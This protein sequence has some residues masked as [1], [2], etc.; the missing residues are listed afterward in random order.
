MNDPENGNWI[1]FE[2]DRGRSA[3][4][5]RKLR[6]NFQDH[7]SKSMPVWLISGAAFLNGFAGIL[8]VLIQRFSGQP[9][10]IDFVLPL[11]VYHWNSLLTLF[12]GFLLI[13][14]SFKL[15]QRRRSAWWLTLIG[16]GLVI[17]TNIGR[18]G[19]WYYLLP[20]IITIVLLIWGYRR[21]SVRSEVMNLRREVKLGFL[22][23]AISLSY[24]IAGFWLLDKK[25]F[26]IEFNL[27]DSI[28]RTLRQF[29]LIGNID[30]VARTRHATWFMDSL[31]LMGIIGGSLFFYSLFRPIEYHLRILPSQRALMKTL[32]VKFGVSSED[33]FK[34]WPEKSYF[35][36]KNGNA[37]IAYR[38]SGG[39]AICLGDPVGL[40]E[41]L[42]EVVEQFMAYCLDN[43]WNV[44]FH[45]ARPDMLGIY[46]RLGLQSIKIGEEALINLDHF[47]NQSFPHNRHLRN[48]CN[49]FEKGGYH[50]VRFLP[51][52][53]S[54][55][56][57]QLEEVSN[58]WLT[59]PGRHERT[60]SLGY[61][62]RH[63]LQEC[64]VDTVQDLDGRI[65]A[66]VNEVPS[67]LKSETTIDLMRHRIDA[68]NGVMDFLFVQLMKTL[69]ANGYSSF[70]LGLAPYA[71]VG[72]EANDPLEEKAIHQIVEH[73]TR[74]FSY[75]GM[76][77][78]KG[79]FDPDWEDRFMI[80]QGG[81]IGLVKTAIAL[82]Q[83]TEKPN[84]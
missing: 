74:F 3:V 83:L 31:N 43:G 14:L 34:L 59:I 82:V 1:D 46:N 62:D 81:V 63:Y 25:D 78:Y 58:E 13:Y 60:F 39:Q 11:G 4:S 49:R 37:G 6:S 45:Q 56:L 23:L 84:N 75:K 76:R 17:L 8:S 80:Y 51:T 28:V 72:N 52:H 70:N 64:P 79:K 21:F 26:G 65:L 41:E 16:S 15:F 47:N 7:F 67:Y 57:E 9:K 5:K 19:S 32:I 53:D 69:Q 29:L 10:F 22:S 61:F 42:E 68:P 27:M 2:K 55:F 30:L 66:F 73:L 48:T 33:Y 12:F 36:S 54:K 71:G 38:T 20:P 50:L 77:D 44:A 35:F 18:G 40:A 24:G